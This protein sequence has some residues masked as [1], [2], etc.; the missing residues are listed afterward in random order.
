MNEKCMAILG[1]MLE[2]DDP[3]LLKSLINGVMAGQYKYVLTIDLGCGNTSVAVSSIQKN[4]GKD[5]I[6]WEYRYFDNKTQQWINDKNISIPTMLG[7]DHAGQPVLGPEAMRYG[8]VAENFKCVPYPAVLDNTVYDSIGRRKTISLREIWIDY[9]RAVIHRAIAYVQKNLY[10]DI[11]FRNTLIVVGRPADKAWEQNLDSYRNLIYNS[12]VMNGVDLCQIITFSEAKASMQYVRTEKKIM[13]NWKKGILV[14]DLGASTCDAEFLAYDCPPLEYSISMAGRDVD[15]LLGHEILSQ[16]YPTDCQNLESTQIPDEA[17]FKTNWNTLSMTRSQFA[18]LM[19][20]VKE[21]TCIYNSSNVYVDAKK[22]S[23][24]IALLTSLLSQKKFPFT[25]TDPGLCAFVNGGQMGNMVLTD[26]WYNHL[27]NL[28]AYMLNQLNGRKPDKVIVT[29]GT[30]NLVGVQNAIRNGFARAKWPAHT[31]P[32]VIVLN[33]PADYERTV[34][35]GAA[36]YVLNVIHNMS[37]ILNAPD[38]ILIAAKADFKNFAPSIITN[39]LSPVVQSK[40]Q[41][42]LNNWV[43]LPNG[44]TGATVNALQ[45]DMK[46]IDFNCRAYNDAIRDAKQEIENKASQTA[47]LPQTMAEILQIL[48]DL[49]MKAQFNHPITLKKVVLNINTDIINNAVLKGLPSI[50]ACMSFFHFIKTILKLDN[51]PLPQS[52]RKNVVKNFAA[53]SNIQ[54]S[55]AQEID[56]NFAGSFD[57]AHGFGIADSIMENLE[58]DINQA[59]FL[60]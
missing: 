25:C 13:L 18:Y 52:S 2:I 37:L 46:A 45:N 58:T 21:A 3:N 30:A 59:M 26:T 33:Q 42:V 53:N 23:V 55:L 57:Q 60:G 34:P 38:K 15:G 9:F 43:K 32:D 48:T 16:F 6:Q 11:T 39:K 19:R 31:W 41:D 17:F 1:K 36:S 10:N 51:N 28:V 22:V 5:L 27:T 44:D 4:T 35:F 50:W 47:N 14:I 12:V 54:V 20:V 7:Y 29:G 56:N 24:D 49:S 40:V 8:N